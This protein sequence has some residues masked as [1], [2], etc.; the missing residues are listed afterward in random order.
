MLGSIPIVGRLFSSKQESVVQR[1]LMVFIRP[2]ILMDSSQTSDI[3][4]EKYNFIDAQ[5]LLNQ[6]ATDLIDLRD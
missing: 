5:R 4:L 3:S 6:K 2:K 1:N